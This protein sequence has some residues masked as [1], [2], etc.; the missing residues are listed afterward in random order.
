MRH[1]EIIGI[2]EQ[3][4]C[5]T[6]QMLEAAHVGDWDRV[7]DLETA[8]SDH[9]AVIQRAETVKTLTPEQRR[10]KT[11]VIRTILDNDRHIRELASPWMAQLSALMQSAGTERKLSQAYGG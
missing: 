8:C 6:G 7:I 4:A 5:I 11:R 9:I 3:V 1:Q 2:Y 10:E